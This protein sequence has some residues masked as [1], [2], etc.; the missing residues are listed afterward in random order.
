MHFYTGGDLSKFNFVGI[1]EKFDKSI[2]LLKEKNL[3][4]VIIKTKRNI[5]RNKEQVPN[6]IKK[7]IERY[8]Q[9]VNCIKK[10]QT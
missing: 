6:N 8:N 10:Q 3:M 7:E 1:T 9:L 2:R 5:G 4:D